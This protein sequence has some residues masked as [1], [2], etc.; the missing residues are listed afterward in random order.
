M[1]IK[2]E[3]CSVPL[4]LKSFLSLTFAEIGLVHVSLVLLWLL[5]VLNK[6]PCSIQRGF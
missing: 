1:D 6:K 3:N 2:K 5:S 4:F